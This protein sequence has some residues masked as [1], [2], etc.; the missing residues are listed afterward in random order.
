[1]LA[2]SRQIA[3]LSLLFA[4]F[5]SACAGGTT[6]P[7]RSNL[8]SGKTV[9]DTTDDPRD[10][11]TKDTSE[12]SDTTTATDSSTRKDSTSPADSTAPEDSTMPG[13]STTPTDTGNQGDTS[14]PADTIAAIDATPDAAPDTNADTSA[15]SS[16]TTDTSSDATTARPIGW[17][18]LQHPSTLQTTVGQKTKPIYGRVF[19]KKCT[20][21]SGRCSNIRAELGWGDPS[22]DPSNN[23]GK[24]NWK[25]ASFNAGHTSSNND[26]YQATI[27]PGKTGWF[28]YAYRFSGDGG[29]TW[30]YCD[31]N[32]T[33]TGGFTVDQMGSLGVKI[34][35]PV[36]I[37]W[38]NLKH[39][40]SLTISSG[41][42]SMP[43]YGRVFSKG[44]TENA[45]QCTTILGQVGWG[46]TTADPSQA[47]T[48]FN[49]VDAMLNT[50]HTS[51]NNDEHQAKITPSTPGSYRLFYRFSG[52]GGVN[53]TYCDTNG[54]PPFSPSDA[55]SLTVN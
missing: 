10:T 29:Q 26:E 37:G 44:C 35:N 34:K 17:C 23:P 16:P 45:K 1:M 46:P 12:P 53:W 30:T 42:T 9:T 41:S 50:G 36:S 38:C 55:G 49:W 51:N 43:I 18:N 47:P 7:P 5:V 14:Q 4:V 6:D 28:A 31:Q 8:D 32:G 25:K 54:A 33:N 20:K 39:P 19:S 24:F 40:T 48:R 2:R 27:T 11:S 52:D 22:V 15:D 21:N 3:G 13:D